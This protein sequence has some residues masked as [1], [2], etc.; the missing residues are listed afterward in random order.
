[1][2]RYFLWTSIFVVALSASWAQPLSTRAGTVRGELVCACPMPGNWTVEL[3]NDVMGMSET[4]VVNPDK[5]FEFRSITPGTHELRVISSS[6]QV[7]HRE[8]VSINSFGQPLSIHVPDDSSANRSTDGTRT[9]SLQ[10]LQHKVPA[11]AQKAFQKGEQAGSKGNLDLARTLFQEA[12]NI[13]P[14]F[15]DAYNELGATE[16]GLKQ[17]PAAAEHFQKAIDLAPEHPK[18][19][20]NLSIVLAQMNRFHEAGQM[21][22]LALK[23]TPNSGTMHYI[24]GVSLLDEHGDLDAAIMHFERA[25]ADVPGAHLTVAELLVQCGRSQDAVHHLEEYLRD[26][27]PDDSK[28]PKAEAR[29]AQLRLA[30]SVPKE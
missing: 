28:R 22:R 16:A 9:I 8:V 17:L 6:G 7:L 3:G 18:A 21:A 23:A 26:A 19:L 13:D 5:T 12:V 20:S 24:V 2:R 29:L 4:A 14:G 1:V 30:A 10:Q 15:A 27:A 11:A 25:T